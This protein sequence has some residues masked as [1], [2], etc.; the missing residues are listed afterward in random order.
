M[1]DARIPSTSGLNEA[2]LERLLTPE[3]GPSDE[4][5]VRGLTRESRMRDRDLARIAEKKVKLLI[6]WARKSEQYPYQVEIPLSLVRDDNLPELFD[7]PVYGAHICAHLRPE[8]RT[9]G[10][11]E[12]SSADAFIRKYPQRAKH[13]QWGQGSGLVI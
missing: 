8:W 12:K 2:D 6:W 10:F 9:Y 11:A 4:E 3:R 7:D 5:I 13:F 1:A